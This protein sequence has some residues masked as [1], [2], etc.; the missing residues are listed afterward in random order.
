[1]T[2]LSMIIR[3]LQLSFCLVFLFAGNIF[4]QE[5]T[6]PVMAPLNPE[7]LNYMNNNTTRFL[8]GQSVTPD[9]HPLGH[10]P[11]P[12]D[13]S[14][15]AGK[16]V[17]QST[18]HAMAFLPSSFDLRT[19][20]KVSPVR[21]QLDCNNCWTFATM[22]SLESNLLPAEIWDFSEYNLNMNHG[23][24]Y[25]PCRGGNGTMATAYLARWGDPVY[26]SGP[27]TESDDPY[28]SWFSPADSP[29]AYTPP[30]D[31]T[32]QKHVQEVLFL[33]PRGS[34]TDNGNIKQAI[35]NYGAVDGSYFDDHTNASFYKA[36]SAAYYYNGAN[37]SNHA[38]TIIGWDD[39]FDAG[40][41][42]TTPAGNG[43]FLIKN[44]WGTSF[45]QG[46]YFWI[47]YYDSVL[48]YSTNYVFNGGQPATN[49]TRVYQYDPLG[50]TGNSYGYGST[51][52][53]FA[54]VFT[55]AATEQLTAVSIYTNDVDVSYSI[56]VY[57]DVG[58]T[59][60]SGMPGGTTTGSIPTPGYHTVTLAS[61]VSI[62]NGQKFSVVVRLTNSSNTFPIQLEYPN[63]GYSSAATAGEGQS[64]VS[65]N[66]TKWSDITVAYNSNANVCL[67]AFTASATPPG[68][69]CSA[70]LSPDLNLH[71]PI[72][73]FNQ[74]SYWVDFSYVP[75]T[76]NF[77]IT[78]SGVIMDASPYSSCAPGT[79]SA[80]LKLHI[81]ALTFGNSSYW[82]DLRYAH[83]LTFSLSG[84]GRN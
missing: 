84:A 23:F 15:L 60:T 2:S 67:K 55:A 35:M 50:W 26:M 81:P 57:T 41:F 20:G 59:P 33:P 4:A 6:D 64:Y 43:A 18:R 68:S 75:S 63:A 1:M 14:H 77:K 45:G 34:S 24:D 56:Y 61:P 28:P 8:R 31:A 53:W 73:N 32:V 37:T 66:G 29:P 48:G 27:L 69:P 74:A 62:T 71:I 7:F 79:L 3:S 22:G 78:N 21:T 36:A 25:P 80:D 30:A 44:S 16:N 52:G 49:Y 46:G 70:S 5:A 51:T 10:V 9:G 11:S 42:S 82:A 40:N 19:V 13:L 54:N 83:D 17:F 39:N 65:Y 72:V 58:S 76:A 12:V 38:I 47:S